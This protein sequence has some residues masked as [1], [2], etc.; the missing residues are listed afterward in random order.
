MIKQ[1]LAI[2]S[3][4]TV[5]STAAL[6][7]ASVSIPF[8][9]NGGIEE[10][11]A[12]TDST[13]YLR[14]RNRDWYKAELTGPCSGLSFATGIS[15]VTAPNGSFDNTSSVVVDGQSCKVMKLEKSEAPPKRK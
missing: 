13:L 10:W 12:D 11:H 14:S 15:Y 9:N 7:A 3:A 6:A 5:L 1:S 8:A 2:F 4:L